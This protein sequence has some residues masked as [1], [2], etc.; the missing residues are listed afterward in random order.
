MSEPEIFTLAKNFGH[1]VVN[2]LADGMKKVS[3]EEFNKRLDICKKCDKFDDKSVRC[4]QCGC[5]L[6]IKA[7]WNSE[8]CPLGLW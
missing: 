8:K 5:F 4:K 1:S 2:H 3:E 7:S 6:N